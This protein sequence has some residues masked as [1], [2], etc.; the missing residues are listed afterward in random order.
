MI[1]VALAMPPLWGFLGLFAGGWKIALVAV[2][3]FALFG[4][5]LGP[6][7]SRWLAPTV[8]RPGSAS[9][10]RS[11]FGDRLYFLL[12]VMAATAIATW[13]LARMAFTYGPRPPG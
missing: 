7:A 10:P 8:H 2:G 5:R 6:F 12:V 13:I 3:V 4:R 11:R 1:T 9:R